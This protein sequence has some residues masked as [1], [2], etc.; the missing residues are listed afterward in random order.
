MDFRHLGHYV[1]DFQSGG[2]TLIRTSVRS[3]VLITRELAADTI[4]ESSADDTQFMSRPLVDLTLD[5]GLDPSPFVANQVLPI[6]KRLGGAF[7]DRIGIGRSDNVDVRIPLAQV[8]KYHAYFSMTWEGLWQITDA[9]STNGTFVGALRLGKLEH[10]LLDD[11]A[12]VTL[13]PYRFT[14]H[15]KDGFLDVVRGRVNTA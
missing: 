13:G 4:D 1:Q 2:E 11:G 3:P 8:S 14:F 15:S 10:A 12:I 6:K 5:D 9:G 7:P